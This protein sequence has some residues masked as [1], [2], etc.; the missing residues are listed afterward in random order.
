MEQLE[1]RDQE[2]DS[3]KRELDEYKTHTFAGDNLDDIDL[4][5]F[6]HKIL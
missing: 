6:V 3:Q 2:I 4:G 5:K 1:L